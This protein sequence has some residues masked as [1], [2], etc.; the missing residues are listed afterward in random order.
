MR[1]WKMNGAGNDFLILNNLEERLPPEALPRIART[2]CQRHMSIGA[3]G[4]M[5]VEAAVDAAVSSRTVS[6]FSA[7]E[8]RVSTTDAPV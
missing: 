1:F 7:R 6:C 8:A 3:D 5:A 2:L 4:L